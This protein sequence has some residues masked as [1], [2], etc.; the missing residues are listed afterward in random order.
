MLAACNKN[1]QDMNQCRATAHPACGRTGRVDMNSSLSLKS[2]AAKV[3]RGIKCNNVEAHNKPSSLQAWQR[4]LMTNSYVGCSPVSAASMMSKAVS[5]LRRNSW[6][7]SP[8][9]EVG[10]VTAQI[11]RCGQGSRSLRMD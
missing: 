7:S 11:D 8:L 5:A 6:R 1:P 2:L 4:R 3:K 10:T 9:H